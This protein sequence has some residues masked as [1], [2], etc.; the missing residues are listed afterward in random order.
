MKD[1]RSEKS[2]RSST[3]KPDLAWSPMANPAVA[4]LLDHLAQELAREY[5]QLMEKAAEDENTARDQQ[6]QDEEG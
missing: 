6:P 4:E 3:R 5:V 2:R 1:A